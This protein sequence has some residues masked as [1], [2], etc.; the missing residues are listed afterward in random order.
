MTD[1]EEDKRRFVF[2]HLRLRGVE[3]AVSGESR[4]L[5]AARPGSRA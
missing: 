5:V 2:G 1:S 4:V 3:A